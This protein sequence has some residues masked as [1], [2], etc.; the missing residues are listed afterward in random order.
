MLKIKD[1]YNPLIMCLIFLSRLF[2]FLMANLD[3][4][5]EPA[6]LERVRSEG[7]VPLCDPDN[8]SNG[9][10]ST[11]GDSFKE[12]GPDYFTTRD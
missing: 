8:C 4:N 5:D 7:A 1:N 10:A 12:R 6:W 9:W 3:G 11:L 2:S